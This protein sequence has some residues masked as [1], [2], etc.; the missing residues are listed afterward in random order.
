MYKVEGEKSGLGGI[1]N[2]CF[3]FS[4]CKPINSYGMICKNLVK[5]SEK[6]AM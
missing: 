1:Y 6:Y 5:C 2:L 3:P 4:A